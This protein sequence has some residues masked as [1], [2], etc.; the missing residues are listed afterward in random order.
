M[1]KLY[2]LCLL[3][4]CLAFANTSYAQIGGQLAPLQYSEHTYS[5]K[6]GDANYT[7]SWGI[8]VSTTTAD[9]IE[10]N[11]ATP[12]T[13]FEVLSST[14]SGGIAYYKVRFAV[15]NT[16]MTTGDY[17]V[18][19]KEV[20]NDTKLCTKAVVSNFHLY[21]A[22]DVDVELYDPATDE[23]KCAGDLVWKEKD[24]SSTTT[25]RYKVFVNYP[26]DALGYIG[27]GG[28]E[29]WSF[30]FRVQATG[31][32]GA[33]STIKS[34]SVA[35]EGTPPL[36]PIPTFTVPAN[37]SNKEWDCDVSPSSVSPLVFTVVYNDVLGVS[38]NIE[39][40]IN[41]ILGAYEEPDVDEATNN[42]DDNKVTNILY[43]LPNVS[44]IVAWGP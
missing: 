41:T 8:Y 34:V 25:V 26:T 33:S 11:V 40:S 13:G 44:E 3:I 21:P 43:E 18:G 22:F 35:S 24:L 39:F 6:M 15:S 28:R 4:T 17:V 1:R 12:V 7:P 42:L 19:Y 5:V 29:K 10:D 31:V 23:K 38:Q 9:N 36:L 16:P 32:S 20:T 27:T 2:L 37:T 14:K 30:K